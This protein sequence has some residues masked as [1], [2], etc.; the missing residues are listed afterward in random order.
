MTT[1]VPTAQSPSAVV[2][3]L[4]MELLS[5]ALVLVLAPYIWI[6]ETVS[7]VAP[8]EEMDWL[9]EKESADSHTLPL[10]RLASE[11]PRDQNRRSGPHSGPGTQLNSSEVFESGEPPA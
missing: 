7:P 11:P 9:E 5:G 2:L 1:S 4:A 10:T 8:Y 6:R 3:L